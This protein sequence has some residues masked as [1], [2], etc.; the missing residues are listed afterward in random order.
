MSAP[1]ILPATAYALSDLA[2]TVQSV[3]LHHNA[4][5]DAVG[6]ARGGVVEDLVTRSQVR[7]LELEVARLRDRE[8]ITSGELI[9]GDE[10]A[11]GMQALRARL[12]EIE[13]AEELAEDII[14]AQRAVVQ[15]LASRPVCNW[16]GQCRHQRQATAAAP[17]RA[18]P[19]FA[20]CGRSA[21]TC[22][23]STHG[24]G[25]QGCQADTSEPT[26]AE[27]VA[28]EWPEGFEQ[29]VQRL[30]TLADAVALFDEPAQAKP[31]RCRRCLTE[32]GDL[33]TLAGTM[34]LCPACGN[35]RCPRATD[36]RHACTGSN[37]PGQTGSWYGGMP[38]RAEPV[39]GPVWLTDERIAQ[40]AAQTWGS[41]GI[42]PQSAAA[43]ARA[44]EA[45]MLG[46]SG[47]VSAAPERAADLGENI[48][49]AQRAQIR[50]LTAERDAA[51]AELAQARE[52]LREVQWVSDEIPYATLPDYHRC[53]SCWA[54]RREG[55]ASDCKLNA[56]LAKGK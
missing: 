38:E 50:T 20:P 33:L 11:S 8:N 56:A 9:T 2:G 4:A 5:M 17:E 16:A 47:P 51:R 1:K 45:W 34:I 24:C 14:E 31:C 52:V 23:R 37:E 36:H 30:P 10:L 29:A 32:R 27:L 46:A 28:A 35:K 40:I 49:E 18:E 44:I 21:G 53:P 19:R 55:H 15:Q 43:F 13:L 41:A 22:G 42:A 39:Q 25:R 7:A 54:E 3:Y 26:D 6:R 12:A 48:I